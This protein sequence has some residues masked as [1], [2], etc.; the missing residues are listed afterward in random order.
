M[1]IADRLTRT[2]LGRLIARY[3]HSVC[4]QWAIWPSVTFDQSGVELGKV[5]AERISPELETRIEPKLAQDSSINALIRRYRKIK[6]LFGG[7]STA[8]MPTIL[9]SL[10][11]CGV[12][13]T[14]SASMKTCEDLQ[15]QGRLFSQ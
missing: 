14:T 5:L 2:M 12:M 3:E 13:Q 9:Q 10:G 7:A 11:Q 4:T 1:I 6:G 15:R 8:A